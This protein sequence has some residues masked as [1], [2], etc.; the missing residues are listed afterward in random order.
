MNYFSFVSIFPLLATLFASLLGSTAY[1]VDE[2]DLLQPDEAFGFTLQLSEGE[3]LVARW[4]VAE[5]YYIYK[6]KLK[7]SVAKGSSLKL[8]DAIFPVSTRLDDPAFGDV[9]IFRGDVTVRYPLSGIAAVTASDVIKAKYQGCA[10]VGVCYPPIRKKFLVSDLKPVLLNESSTVKQTD[11]GSTAPQTPQL[12][13]QD[14]IA[15]SLSSDN[16]VWTLATFFGFGLLL[17]FT[18]CVFPM[19]PIL[20]G[21]IIGEGDNIS[22]RRAFSLSLAYVLAMASAYTLVGVLAALFGTNLQIWFQNPWVLVSF[23]IV[24]VI[25]SLSMFGFFELQMP[26]SIQSKI[27]SLS[28]RQKGGSLISAAIMGLLSALIVGPCVT[29]PL[30]GALIYIGQTGDA[31]LGGS[32]LFALGLGMGAPLLLIGTSAGKLMPRAGAWMEPI[33]SVF[34]VLMLAVAI[35]LLDRVLPPTATQLLWAVLLIMSGIYLGAL[36]QHAGDTTQ[37]Q[38]F[39]KGLGFV[40]LLYGSIMVI[41]ASTGRANLLHP[42]QSLFQSTGGSTGSSEHTGVEFVQIKGVDGLEKAIASAQQSGQRVMLDFYADWCISCKEMEALTFT[43]PKVKSALSGVISLQADVT[44][45]DDADQALLE[46]FG[47]IGPPA[48]IFFDPQGVELKALRIVGFM[49]ADK[50]TPHVKSALE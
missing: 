4:Q 34:G 18:P 6:D 27:N 49:P 11:E 37:W 17:A 25:L 15:A 43:D 16:F 3:M 24:F 42:L 12:S 29:A 2:A 46:Y 30:V 14:S 20:S 41:G 10:D 38:L 44:A 47:I 36:R 7:L 22:T 26:S 39:W 5:G 31:I 45:N 9:E 35:W 33:K 8:G 50:F 32:A 21:I 1:A 23:A 19:I 48:I 13:E 40:L 28:N